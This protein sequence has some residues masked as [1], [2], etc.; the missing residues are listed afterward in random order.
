MKSIGKQKESAFKFQLAIS[1]RKA[2]HFF[3]LQENMIFGSLISLV[4]TAARWLMNNSAAIGDVF[5]AIKNVA[6]GST[7][8][9]ENENEI[10]FIAPPETLDTIP[11]TINIQ[12]T[13]EDASDKLYEKA[14]TGPPGGQAKNTNE[15]KLN[16]IWIEPSNTVHKVPSQTMY[17]ELAQHLNEE[18]Y[19]LSFPLDAKTTIDLPYALAQSVLASQSTPKGVRAKFDDETLVK[20]APFDIQSEDD[21]VKFKA[22]FVHY[23]I[24]LGKGGEE[25]AWHVALHAGSRMT[26]RYAAEHE[27][28]KQSLVYTSHKR[29][30]QGA[31]WILTCEIDWK[32]VL[33]AQ[34]CHDKLKKALDVDQP[35]YYL[36]LSSLDATIQTL[37]LVVQAKEDPSQVR[38]YLEL[39]VAQIA[40]E[41]K[42]KSMHLLDKETEPLMGQ[43]PTAKLTNYSI[44]ANYE[45]TSDYQM[46]Y[47][48][49]LEALKTANQERE[50]AQE[51][52][53]I[54]IQEYG[55]VICDIRSSV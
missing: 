26:N 20:I 16:A 33:I 37:K 23:N 44:R 24:P 39:K 43:S 10:I 15:S 40:R 54:D 34:N 42:E 11:S 35:E 53:M 31:V 52:E 27:R 47:N 2:L 29:P 12:K 3:F 1:P 51:P 18:G 30:P 36:A 45:H 22:K 14:K 50:S 41:T 46:G 28:K 55:E 38:T 17:R 19:P 49:Y 8:S 6:S 32:T 5:K 21:D 9:T 25:N 13:L 48:R 7:R 4:P